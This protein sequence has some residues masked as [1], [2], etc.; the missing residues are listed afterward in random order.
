MITTNTSSWQAIPSFSGE[1]RVNNVNAQTSRNQLIISRTCIAVGRKTKLSDLP[2][3][4]V[5]TKFVATCTPGMR[6]ISHTP[7]QQIA[8]EEKGNAANVALWMNSFFNHEENQYSPILDDAGNPDLDCEQNQ[9]LAVRQDIHAVV[10]GEVE[11]SRS[12]V[13]RKFRKTSNGATY[14]NFVGQPSGDSLGFL[15]KRN[16]TSLFNAEVTNW[17]VLSPGTFTASTA[18]IISCGT[19]AAMVCD[20]AFTALVAIIINPSKNK[21]DY[22]SK[23]YSVQHLTQFKSYLR[24]V[25]NTLSTGKAQEVHKTVK[26]AGATNTNGPLTTNDRLIIEVAML[27]HTT[28]PQGRDSLTPNK[29]TWRFIARNR[30]DLKSVPCRLSVEAATEREARRILAPHFILLLAARLPMQGVMEMITPSTVEKTSMEVRHAQ[31]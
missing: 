1:L 10:S 26:P 11:P 9:H 6:K 25:F 14:E 22:A 19:L 30:I 5:P 20:L 24:L 8:G 15:S 7:N 23:K 16:S 4:E 21:K 3:L 18:S 13:L 27:D 31:A 12:R 28:H 17:P 2:S 29:F